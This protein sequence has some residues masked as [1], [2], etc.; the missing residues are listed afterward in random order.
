M[1]WGEGLNHSVESCNRG[2]AGE[3]GKTSFPKLLW[4]LTIDL[5]LLDDMRVTRK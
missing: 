3:I 4:R 5:I 2:T 1:L